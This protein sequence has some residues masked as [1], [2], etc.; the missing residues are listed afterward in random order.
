MTKSVEHLDD[1]ILLQRLHQLCARERQ[2]TAQ[3]LWHLAE[4]DRRGLYRDR[5]YSS[6]FNYCMKALHMS[7]AEAGLRIRMARTARTYPV[8]YQHLEQG[9]LHL[10][11]ITLARY[12]GRGSFPM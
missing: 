3:L 5:G 6:L 4:V 8:I 11:A 2:V 10:S 12:K 1:R 9:E 7:E